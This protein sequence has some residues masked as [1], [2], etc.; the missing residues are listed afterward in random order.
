MSLHYNQLQTTIKLDKIEELWDL[1]LS[2]TGRKTQG[3][4][5]IGVPWFSAS[6]EPPITVQVARIQKNKM[7]PAEPKKLR[8]WLSPVCIYMAKTTQ[9]FQRA[10][11][12]GLRAEQR[13]KSLNSVEGHWSSGS[14]RV[15]KSQ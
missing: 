5:V 9:I 13:Y 7:V 12:M 4:F 8:F 1:R 2:T 6:G 15:E 11:A 14:A 3:K 10:A